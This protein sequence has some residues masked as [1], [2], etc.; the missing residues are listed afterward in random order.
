MSFGIPHSALRISIV[1]LSAFPPVAVRSTKFLTVRNLLTPSP[2][3]SYDCVSANSLQWAGR[4]QPQR[5]EILVAL[6]IGGDDVGTVPSPGGRPGDKKE[7]ASGGKRHAGSGDPAYNHPIATADAL[8][9][10]HGEYEMV[11]FLHSSFCLLHFPPPA[12]RNRGDR[13]GLILPLITA[14]RTASRPR[15]RGDRGH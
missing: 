14:N 15:N 13:G 12:P 5:G 11:L 9:G 6:R 10:K 4:A 1:L 2:R 8:S 3:R 7:A